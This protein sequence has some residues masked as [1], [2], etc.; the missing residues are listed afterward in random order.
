MLHAL[1]VWRRLLLRRQQPLLPS[2]TRELI[3]SSFRSLLLCT[4]QV[5]HDRL[6]LASD[7]YNTQICKTCGSLGEI[8]APSLGGMLQGVGFTCRA[9]AAQNSG[10][11]FTTT[12][13]LMLLTKELGAMNIGIKHEVQPKS[14][15]EVQAGVAEVTDKDQGSEKAEA[16]PSLEPSASKRRVAELDDIF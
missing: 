14:E 6:V 2:E 1:G 7:V 11:E 16:Q 5:L 10:L 15:H 4:T 12:Y 8:Q 3:L 9:C 13:C